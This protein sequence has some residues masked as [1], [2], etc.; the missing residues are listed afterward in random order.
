MN[1]FEQLTA[2]HYQREKEMME[3]ELQQLDQ[4]KIANDFLRKHD[5]LFISPL[6]FQGY[7]ISYFAELSKLPGDQKTAINQMIFNNFFDLGWTAAFT[8]GYCIRCTYIQPFLP[9]I[10]HS[11]ILTFQRDYEGAIKTLIPII[12]GILRKY[13]LQEH[14]MAMSS[15]QFS[16]LKKAFTQIKKDLIDGTKDGLNNRRDENQRPICFDELQ[17]E[18]LLQLHIQYEENWFSFITE[19]IDQSFYLNTKSTVLTNEINRHA[20]LHE[21]GLN[22]NY[23]LENYIKVYFVLYFLTWACLRKERKSL[24]NEIEPYRAFEKSEAYNQIIQQA[25]KMDY[26]KHLLLKNYPGY[27]PEIFSEKF[28]VTPIP[29]PK[30]MRKKHHLFVRFHQYLWRKGISP[31]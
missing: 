5:W 1:E 15:I 25:A 17:K 16:H 4:Y 18:T 10:E 22:F 3:R 2:Y 28:Q 31:H 14:G 24:L 30:Q 23:E 21:F 19:F 8:E 7:Q 20:I 11:L 27:K 29:I 9:S 6:F 12:E 13:L 26:Q